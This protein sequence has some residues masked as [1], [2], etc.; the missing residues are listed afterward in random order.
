MSTETWKAV[1]GYEGTYEVSDLGNVRSVDRTDSLGRSKKGV[2]LSLWIDPKGRAHANLRG[3]RYTVSR[4]VLNAF[5]GQCPDGLEA[6]HNDGNPA[7][8]SLDNLRWGTRSSNTL[9]SVKHGT[10]HMARRTHCPKGHPL[11]EG[12]LVLWG[13]ARGK[14]Q[15]LTC[16]H[17]WHFDNKTRISAEV[18]V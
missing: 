9:D 12:N 8:N 13:L 5:V 14:R 7:N 11:E 6:C 10:H 15:C 1:D 17:Q 18:A 4:L 2:T 16:Q 3:K